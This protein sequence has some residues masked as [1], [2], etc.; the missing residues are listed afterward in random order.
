MTEPL[1]DK[2]GILYA[3]LDLN[4]IADW[5]HLH[6]AVGHYSRPDLLSLLTNTSEYRVTQPMKERSNSYFPRASTN[7]NSI[8]SLDKLAADIER[9]STELTTLR[10]AFSE[11]LTVL[12]Q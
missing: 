2:E 8:N 1:K 11:R 7:V 3:E 9:L 4:T 6:D 5:A 10:S 12:N